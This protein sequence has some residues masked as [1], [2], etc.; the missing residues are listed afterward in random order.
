MNI[1][2]TQISYLCSLYTCVQ[3]F[4]NVYVGEEHKAHVLKVK[5]KKIKLYI[6]IYIYETW[7]G[8]DLPLDS[9][10]MVLSGIT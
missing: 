3:F 7:S 10:E 4:H 6:Y 8:H 2:R 5:K 1:S 9:G